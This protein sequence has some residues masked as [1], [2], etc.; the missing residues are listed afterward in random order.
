M[1]AL[2]ACMNVKIM[3][4]L[5]MSEET[6]NTNL[7]QDI[8]VIRTPGQMLIELVEKQNVKEADLKETTSK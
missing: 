7:C 5:S 2:I 1:K 8:C 6:V 3:H 4:F